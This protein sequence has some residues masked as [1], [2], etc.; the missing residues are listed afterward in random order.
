MIV[1]KKRSPIY[2]SLSIFFTIVGVALCSYPIF[3][4]GIRQYK[5]ISGY[6]LLCL[7]ILSLLNGVREILEGSFKILGYLSEVMS[8]LIFILAIRTIIIFI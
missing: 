8:S 1:R 2:I 5:L 3:S 6:L 7:S 4:I